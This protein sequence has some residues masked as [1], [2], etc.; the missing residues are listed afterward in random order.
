MAFGNANSGV[1]S[2][3]VTAATTSGTSEETVASYSLPANSLCRT[4]QVLR[5]RAWGATAATGNNKTQ[6]ITFGSAT[7]VSTGALAANDKDWFL[8]ALVVRSDSDAQVMLGGGQANG[9]LVQYD[10]STATEDEDA[11]ITIALKA[12]DATAAAGTLFKGM[13]V[14]MLQNP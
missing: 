12:T 7:V 2:V 11:A 8:E 9:A 1:L 13:I 3:N 6:K 4:G 14:E 10:A 5:I